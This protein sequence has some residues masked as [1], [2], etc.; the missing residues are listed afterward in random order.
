[1][2]NSK[3]HRSQEITIRRC[4]EGCMVLQFGLT[5]IHLDQNLFQQFAQ[6]VMATSIQLDQERKLRRIAE[7][8]TDPCEGRV[9]SVDLDLG[10]EA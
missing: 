7:M 2:H 8:Q 9:E 10:F 5:M 3:H 6:I 1:M 4:S